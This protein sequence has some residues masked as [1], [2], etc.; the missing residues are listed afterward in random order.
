MSVGLRQENISKERIAVQDL[1]SHWYGEGVGFECLF[2]SG[3]ILVAARLRKLAD[4]KRGLR[5]CGST[6][7]RVF[8]ITVLPPSSL[9]SSG[10]SSRVVSRYE[11]RGGRTQ[12]VARAFVASEHAPVMR[13]T[14]QNGR[15]SFARKAFGFVFCHSIFVVRTE[16]IVWPDLV[17]VAWRRRQLGVAIG[18]AGRDVI[19]DK[20]SA[21]SVSSRRAYLVSVVREIRMHALQH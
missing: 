7:V 1:R 5:C 6:V 18:L 3:K 11:H 8:V 16:T 19:K 2:P 10:V 9:Q 13:L 21:N 4:G 15:L 17:Y 14:S 20:W 12:A